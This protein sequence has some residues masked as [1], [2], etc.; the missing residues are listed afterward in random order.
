MASNPSGLPNYAPTPIRLFPMTDFTGGLNIKADAFQL[1]P[2]ES[3]DM[4]DMTV[5]VGGGFVQRQVV[6]PWGDLGSGARIRKVWAYQT[7]SVNQVIVQYLDSSGK[8]NV[9]ASSTGGTSWT[10]VSAAEPNASPLK[11]HA[12]V[13][14]NNF[15][16]VRGS[17]N[18]P[19]RWNGTTATGLGQSWNET[20]GTEGLADGNMPMARYVVVHQQRVWVAYTTE[21]GADFPCRLRWSHAGSAEDWRQEDYIDIDVGR[22]G[23][24]ITGIVE[25][26]DK[27]Y[28]FK[29]SSISVVTGYS[30]SNFAVT[31]ISQR[32]G[33][34]SQ[35]AICV[36]DV[37]LFNFSWPY[38]VYLDR[39]TGPYPIFDKLW[40]LTHDGSFIPAAYRS[41]ITMGW[42]NNN[43]WCSVP[44]NG[45]SYNTR[46]YVYNPWI[47]KNRYLRFLQGPWY[48]YGL[49]ISAFAESAPATGPT[50]WLAAQA[51]GRYVGTLEN[52]GNTDNWGGGSTNISSYFRTRWVDLGSPSVIKR[53]RH[54]DIACRAPGQQAILVEVRKDYDPST[55]YKTYQLNVG[56]TPMGMLWDDGSGVVGGKWD[57]GTGA[58]GGKWSSISTA[59]EV[60][61]RGQSMGSSAAIQMSFYA[62][63][64]QFWGVD[65]VSLKYVTKRIRG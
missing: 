31:T 63:S 9:K 14:N 39:G 24:V 59:Q 32:I 36:T 60:I 45:S 27:L 38:G 62:P 40:P 18:V 43:L 33:A 58:V 50:L 15:Y 13:F 46:T 42:V 28:V 25:F 4:L 7:P 2:N 55:V 20:I 61:I 64:G 53:W 1:G 57:D 12:V 22:D 47:Y 41:E 16:W 51:N 6:Q 65:A 49:G 37:G 48:P 56:T 54:P 29:N 30:T 52:D 34:V 3:P 17:L 19:G 35:E 21:G 11:F 44:Y 10:V 8:S 26:N 5:Q 23:D